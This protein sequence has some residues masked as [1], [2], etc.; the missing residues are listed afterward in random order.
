[1]DCKCN[2]CIHFDLS[3]LGSINEKGENDGDIF[4][5]ECDK[6]KFKPFDSETDPVRFIDKLIE[7]VYLANT[8]NEFKK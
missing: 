4:F 3:S 5:V 2:K 8:C 1:M 7:T 6:F